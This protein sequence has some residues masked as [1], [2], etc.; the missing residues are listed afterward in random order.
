MKIKRL[1]LFLIC[2][3]AC[4]SAPK[5]QELNSGSGYKI[6]SSNQKDMFTV[7]VSVPAGTSPSYTVQYGLRAIGEECQRRGFSYFDFAERATQFDLDGFCYPSKDRR[8]LGV[9]FDG[10]RENPAKFE[11]TD[12]NHK[13]KTFFQ[14]G[15]RIEFVEG[16]SLKS[17]GELKAT[18]AQLSKQ[19][20]YLDIVVQRGGKPV[21]LNEPIA[22]F[23]D[24]N[25]GPEDLKSIQ[26]RV[27]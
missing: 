13:S 18:V 23:H 26:R 15:D 22:L 21:T 1:A 7:R 19:K 24:I 10:F 6:T 12:L 8:A 2:L 4:Q 20:S 3:S 25:L 16:K 27:K 14:L 9:T 5:Y 11:V 17:M